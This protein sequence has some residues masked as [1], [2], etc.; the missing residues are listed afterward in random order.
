MRVPHAC[1]TAH[2]QGTPLAAAVGRVPGKVLEGARA[3]MHLSLHLCRHAK[4]S[5]S[6]QPTWHHPLV[7]AH[8]RSH[9][10]MQ[11]T[12]LP[13]QRRRVSPTLPL[14]GR[15]HPCKPRRTALLR[16][17]RRRPETM[18]ERASEGRPTCKEVQGRRMTEKRGS[19]A[20]WHR[21]GF[22]S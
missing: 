13:W 3:P 17:V 4:N 19:G 1:S 14:E 10:C 16:H 21:L 15:C 8:E 9:A 5:S 18:R 11:A 6:L 22:R 20:S 7:T 2:S 12:W